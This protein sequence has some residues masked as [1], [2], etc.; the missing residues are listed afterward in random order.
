MKIERAFVGAAKPK[1]TISPAGRDVGFAG[2]G[3]TQQRKIAVVK[4][5]CPPAT[6]RNIIPLVAARGELAM[7]LRRELAQG[8]VWE[9]A[10]YI[11][12]GAC[13]LALVVF[14]ALT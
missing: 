5:V 9:T 8:Q 1:A 12:L 4:D 10:A 13:F 3:L 2:I 7:E 11:A 6:P 14:A